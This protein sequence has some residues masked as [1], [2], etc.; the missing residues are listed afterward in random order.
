MLALFPGREQQIT[1]FQQ[2]MKS[3]TEAQGLEYGD[4]TRISNS[5]LAQELAAWADMQPEGEALHKAL[6][7]GYFVDGRDIGDVDVLVELVEVAGLDATAARQVLESRSQSGRVDADWQ[8]SR[9]EGVTGVPTFISAG[10]AVI[11]C[12][13]YPQLLRFVEHLRSLP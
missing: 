9:E 6:Y 8:R 5:R 13:Q 10:L 11:G 2:Q 12:Q 3:L 4:R 1:G 7:R